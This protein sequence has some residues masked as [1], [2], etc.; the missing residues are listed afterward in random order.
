MTKE[1]KSVGNETAPTKIVEILKKLDKW[2]DAGKEQEEKNFAAA[3]HFR[4]LTFFCMI[5]LALQKFG[6]VH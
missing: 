5:L 4:I 6:L 3:P 2:I 1:V